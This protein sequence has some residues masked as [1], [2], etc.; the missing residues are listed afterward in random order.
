[1]NVVE[2][3]DTTNNEL[4]PLSKPQRP[5][6][7]MTPLPNPMFD[8]AQFRARVGTEKLKREPPARPSPPTPS[9]KPETPT[10][11]EQVC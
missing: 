7:E 4:K 1:M 10:R 2:V 3:D 5:V 6:S 9:A 11:P 8:E